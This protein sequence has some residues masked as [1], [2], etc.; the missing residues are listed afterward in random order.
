MEY[1][2]IVE[3]P[4]YKSKLDNVKSIMRSQFEEK[5]YGTESNITSKSTFKENT[6]VDFKFSTILDKIK[7]DNN[8]K[9][10]QMSVLNQRLNVKRMKESTNQE[11]QIR[12]IKGIDTNKFLESTDFVTYNYSNVQEDDQYVDKV[13]YFLP[14]KCQKNTSFLGSHIK[15]LEDGKD[16]NLVALD[17]E[18]EESKVLT[19][20]LRQRKYDIQVIRGKIVELKYLNSFVDKQ[21]NKNESLMFS[22]ELMTSST[23]CKVKMV[24]DNVQNKISEKEEYLVNLRNKESEIT[25]NLTRM[26]SEAGE[27]ILKLQECK[28]FNEKLLKER[29]DLEY[30]CDS[31]YKKTQQFQK[32]TQILKHLAYCNTQLLN[33]NNNESVSRDSKISNNI[34]IIDEK[35]MDKQKQNSNTKQGT[36]SRKIVNSYNRLKLE[37]VYDRN[38]KGM[39]NQFEL[40]NKQ[41]NSV[42]H[43]VQ[44][45]SLHNCSDS[46]DSREIIDSNMQVISKFY[47]KF[48]NGPSEI[49][50]KLSFLWKDWNINGSK[51]EIQYHELLK[52][53]TKKRDK[54]QQ[55]KHKLVDSKAEYE[56]TETLNDS[57]DNLRDCTREHDSQEFFHHEHLKNLENDVNMHAKQ[58]V[59]FEKYFTPKQDVV[60]AKVCIGFYSRQST[61]FDKMTNLFLLM[62]GTL[63]KFV[64]FF[65]YSQE[66]IEKNVNQMRA[67]EDK[68]E[69]STSADKVKIR[70]GILQNS[71]KKILNSGSVSL[72]NSVDYQSHNNIIDTF[73]NTIDKLNIKRSENNVQLFIDFQVGDKIINL[74]IEPKN[75]QKM[76]K[77]EIKK[78]PDIFITNGWADFIMYLKGFSFNILINKIENN[79]KNIGNFVKMMNDFKIV[80]KE[81]R[82]ITRDGTRNVSRGSQRDNFRSKNSLSKASENVMTSRSAEKSQTN[83]NEK[84]YFLPYW[85]EAMETK[86]DQMPEENIINKKKTIKVL[87]FGYNENVN[88]NIM[89]DNNIN[90]KVHFE[91]EISSTNSKNTRQIPRK[92]NIQTNSKKADLYGRKS[93]EKILK[94]KIQQSIHGK[95]KIE[96]WQKKTNDDQETATNKESNYSELNFRNIDVTVDSGDQSHRNDSKLG[97]GLNSENMSTNLEYR[98]GIVKDIK[99]LRDMDTVIRMQ[100][101]NDINPGKI[102][103]DINENC[104]NDKNIYRFVE[105]GS[106]MSGNFSRKDLFKTTSSGKLESINFIEKNKRLLEKKCQLEKKNNMDIKRTT[107][108]HKNIGFSKN[109]MMNST[110]ASAYKE[111]KYYNLSRQKDNMMVD[112]ANKLK[113][114]KSG[115]NTRAV[116]S[117]TQGSRLM[118]KN[119]FFKT[120]MPTLTKGLDKINNLACFEPKTNFNAPQDFQYDTSINNNN[121]SKTQRSTNWL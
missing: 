28:S 63:R 118:E 10:K 109:S 22:S 12:N 88:I 119:A 61:L 2:S 49:I 39:S 93:V 40:P 34:N 100:D 7:H 106:T 70:E 94:N 116:Y 74:L 64:N 96:H 85:K 44:K 23:N 108:S 112:F 114:S 69:T 79:L 121:F 83:M 25:E 76:F 89:N 35:G 33:F 38:S 71:H 16:K 101:K 98:R 60:P 95:G 3:D 62:T 30:D 81:Q 43:K 29:M 11:K 86:F 77:V 90:T 52:D 73:I 53:L 113:R 92:D 15:V 111:P 115:K 56:R 117:S 110:N 105:K 65:P 50:T 99:K 57:C 26:E 42:R 13:T 91:D 59:G 102:I 20:M 19:N 6:K 58:I 72:D 21:C 66:F 27:A 24:K 82:C 87:E 8:K 37:N 36:A 46:D 31:A 103:D 120:G 1:S 55:L 51:K 18:K 97:H 68:S 41:Q 45:S 9:S 47:K 84:D 80:P 78:N 107:T 4:S 5:F 32:V 48:P 104:F 75:F 14:F 54:L 67:I 17:T